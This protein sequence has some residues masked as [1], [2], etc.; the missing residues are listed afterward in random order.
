VA[1]SLSIP[2]VESEQLAALA[3]DRVTTAQPGERATELST[4]GG[5]T[6]DETI[7]KAACALDRAIE[8]GQRRH[9]SFSTLNR[10]DKKAGGAGKM[11]GV[12]YPSRSRRRRAAE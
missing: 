8:N 5:I 1:F 3:V 6:V 2:F 10:A 9:D 4:K 11:T 12:E 7:Q